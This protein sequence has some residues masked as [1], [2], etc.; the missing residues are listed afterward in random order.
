MTWEL[1]PDAI[2]EVTDAVVSTL[3]QHG[4]RIRGPFRQQADCGIRSW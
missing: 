4:A 1:S 2:H 3:L